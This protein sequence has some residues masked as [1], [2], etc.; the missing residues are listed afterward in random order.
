M[1]SKIKIKAMRKTVFIFVL[2]LFWMS[3]SQNR[4][5]K[6][7]VNST[8]YKTTHS[9][10][11]SNGFLVYAGNDKFSVDFFKNYQIKVFK[12][13]FEYGIDKGVLNIMYL[14]TY[15]PNL[16]RDLTLKF[17]DIYKS[18]SDITNWKVEFLNYYP[19][20]YGTTSPQPNYGF[21]HSRQDLDFINAPSAWDITTGNPNIKIGISDGPIYYTDLDFVGKITPIPG[22]TQSL[23]QYSHGTG[24]A[25]AAAAKG[26]NSYGTVGVCMDCDIVEAG[27]SVLGAGGSQ[28][29]YSNLYK[30]AKEGAKVINMSWMEFPFETNNTTNVPEEQLVINDLVNNYR[31]ALV[32]AAGNT[33]SF[34]TP[35]STDSGAP[36]GVRYVFPASYDNVISVS[37][38]RHTGTYS[39]P[40]STAQ[41]TYCCTSPW[42][43]VYTDLQDSASHSID[44]SKAI[45]PRA[46]LRNGYNLTPT[47][48]DGFQSSLTLNDKVDILSTGYDVYWH[49]SAIAGSSSIYTLGTSFS[50]PTVSGTIGL[51]LSVN[52]CLTALESEDIIQLTSVDVENSTLNMNFRPEN[53]PGFE[54]YL[55]FLGAGRLDVGK[56]VTFVNEMK[57][58]NGNAVIT[59]HSFNRFDF[60]L[61]KINNNL[62]IEKVTFRNNCIAHFEARNQIRLLPDTNLLPNTSG[63]VHLSINPN[64]DISCTPVSFPR[65]SNGL[66]EDI[67]TRSNV[68]L[69]PNPNEGNFNLYNLTSQ[70]FNSEIVKVKVFDLNGRILFETNLNKDN[71]K[72]CKIS[73]NNL[74]GGIYNLEISSNSH[75]EVIKFIKL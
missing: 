51:M 20:D 14:E 59:N 13:A 15:S 36:Y 6:Y 31:I 29:I 3:Y 18:Y 66:S 37:A 5:Y 16:A 24:V 40:L 30:M 7:Y 56:A 42:F 73:I 74:S 22:Y 1:L 17:P 60:K 63:N 69:F 75:T 4:L 10:E 65:I 52:D 33:S 35:T 62:T 28:T 45:A 12:Q 72:D 46:V 8:D 34:G 58:I 50:A 71:F 23:Q 2:F 43:P 67:S 32:A 11:N 47:N 25:A 48:P 9:F 26:N 39:L 61:T 57:K 64:V 55:G 68:I 41:N 53:M 21:N 38:V 54:N 19:N 27:M 49:A 70:N 44:G